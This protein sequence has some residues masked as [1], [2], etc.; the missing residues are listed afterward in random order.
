MMGLD[1]DELR[2]SAHR[3]GRLS[4]V[5]C[6]STK[7]C[8]L[9]LGILWATRTDG[10]RVRSLTSRSRYDLRLGIPIVASVT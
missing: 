10:P 7:V 2:L 4:A 6:I 5:G 1:F 3:V 8:V 9:V